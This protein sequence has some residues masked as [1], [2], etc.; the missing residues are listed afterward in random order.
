MRR[1]FF[2]YSRLYLYIVYHTICYFLGA[3]DLGFTPSGIGQI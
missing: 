1:L 2:S 3:I